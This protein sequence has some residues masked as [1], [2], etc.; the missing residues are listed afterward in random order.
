MRRALAYPYGEASYAQ[1][2]V[3]SGRE[4]DRRYR[5]TL[6]KAERGKAAQVCLFAEEEKLSFE[7]G[8]KQQHLLGLQQE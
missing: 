7:H 8:A 4:A 5:G 6:Y 2:P 3:A 1:R